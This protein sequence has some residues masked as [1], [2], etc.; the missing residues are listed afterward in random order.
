LVE[1]VRGEHAHGERGLRIR[2][3]AELIE[4]GQRISSDLFL[5]AKH[6]GSN[7]RAKLSFNSLLQ[8]TNK[9]IFVILLSENRMVL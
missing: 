4:F 7:L 8:P 9:E 2:V 6:N 3:D 5:F 1:D